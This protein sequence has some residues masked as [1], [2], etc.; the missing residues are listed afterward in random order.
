MLFRSIPSD[1]TIRKVIITASC[2]EGGEPIIIRD[3]NNPR[4]KLGG[5]K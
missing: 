1:L 4:E 2:V 3:A 5:K